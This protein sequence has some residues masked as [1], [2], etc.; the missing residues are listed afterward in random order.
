M[1]EPVGI[2]GPIYY[3]GA[4]K[5]HSRDFFFSYLKPSVGVFGVSAENLCEG[6]E[7]NRQIARAKLS[8]ER[9]VRDVVAGVI[10]G[11]LELSAQF[12]CA[13]KIA[14]DIPSEPIGAT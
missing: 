10:D 2:E 1:P 3:G 11:I 6:R 9:K 5:F 13:P 4:P 7:I 8:D 12:Q 14:V